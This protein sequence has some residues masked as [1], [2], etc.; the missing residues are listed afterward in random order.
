M[1]LVALGTQKFSMDRLVKAADEL[2]ITLGEEIFVQKGHSS[3]VPANCEYKDFVDAAEFQKMINEC[4]LLITH[5]G[6]GTIMRGINAKKP[7]I[8]VPRLAKYSEHVDDH[9]VQIAKAF[10]AKKMVLVCEEVQSLYSAVEQSKSFEFMPY[11]APEK[12]IEDI[13]DSFV[14]NER[15]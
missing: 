1:I 10:E 12:Q 13:I 8:V 9:Q 6:V 11:N 5:A 14:E 7:V 3:Y 2:S 15:I 4:S